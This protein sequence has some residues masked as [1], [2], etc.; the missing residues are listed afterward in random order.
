MRCKYLAEFCPLDGGPGRVGFRTSCGR[1]YPPAR[2]VGHIGSDPAQGVGRLRREAEGRRQGAG[3]RGSREA[4]DR[5]SHARQTQTGAAR[6]LSVRR[7]RSPAEAA[8]TGESAPSRNRPPANRSQ[9]PP[10]SR[11][12]PIP[13]PMESGPVSIEAA[14]FKGVTPGV[15]TKEDVAKAWGQP[16]ET[17]QQNGGLVQ[18]YSV[19][20][21]H[22]VEVNYAGDKVSS[23]VIRFDRAFP[24]DAV[25]KQ[26]DLATVRPV[27]V[28]NELG[29]ILGLSYPE[30]GV[31]FA[32]EAGKEPGKPS[33]KV[34]QLVLEPI[35][36]EPFVLRAETTLE[37]RCDLSRRDL[38]QALSLEPDNARAHW[39]YAR[40]LAT[41]EQYEKAAAAAGRGGPTRAR[42]SPLPRDPRPN[43]GPSGPPVR[44]P[45]RGA[46]G[47][48]NQPEAAARQGAGVVP[49]GRSAGLRSETRLQESPLLPHPGHPDC[50]SA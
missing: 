17:A 25:A 5:R 41:M 3:G 40:V 43:A 33:M 50:R 23:V 24:A 14:S 48:R 46:E 35:T 27:L 7:M 1:R 44:G 36:A 4:E 30:R 19:E 11:L 34:A 20:P 31:L 45:G 15:S 21:F 16:K 47:R 28:S 10:T 13:D 42:Q 2:H 37:S 9:R 26:L 18:L 8:P 49:G 12:R 38:E 29:E 39:L 6:N 32:F 22:R